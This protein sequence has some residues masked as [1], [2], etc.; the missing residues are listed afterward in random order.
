MNPIVF[1]LRRPI[2]VMMLVLALALGGTFSI[3]QMQKD[4]FPSLFSQKLR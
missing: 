4:I 2:T 1:A 3:Y